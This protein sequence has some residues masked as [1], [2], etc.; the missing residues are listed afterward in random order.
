[1][2]QHYAFFTFIFLKRK[3]KDYIMKEMSAHVMYSYAILVLS[4]K[5]FLRIIYDPYEN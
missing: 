1:M 3:F 5:L 2:R 4:V